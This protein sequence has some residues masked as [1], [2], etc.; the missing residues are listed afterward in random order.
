MAKDKLLKSAFVMAAM[1]M[2]SRILGLMRD[3]VSAKIFGLGWV[4]DAFLYAFMVPNFFRRIVGEGAL[5]SAF[6]PVY[7]DI[8]AKQGEEAA[9]KYSNLVYTFMGAALF[10][11]ILAVEVVLALLLKFGVF[12]DVIRLAI[13]LL[14]VMFP[15]LWFLCAY[16]IG[17]GILN[18]HGRFFV[19]MI[20]PVLMNM[21]WIATMLWIFPW[22]SENQTARLHILAWALTF[23]G[24][25]HWAVEWPFLKTIGFQFQFKWRQL[26]FWNSP[27][28]EGLRRSWKL[29]TPVL[30]SFGAVQ[31]NMLIDTAFAYWVGPGANSSLW[32]GNRVMQLPLSMFGVAMGSALLPMLS[33]QI[34]NNQ[35]E[36]ARQTL[37]FSLTVTFMIVLP[38]SAGLIVLAPDIMRLLFER[39]EFDAAATARTASVLAAYAWGLFAYSGQKMMITGYYAAHDSKTPMRISLFSLLLNVVLNF[40]L[41]PF[42][43]ETGLALSTSISAIVQLLL[44]MFFYPRCVASFPFRETVKSFLKTLIASVIMAL[45]ARFLLNAWSGAAPASS[46]TMYAIQVLGTIAAAGV[47][48][49][50]IS[51]VIQKKEASQVFAYLRRRK[52]AKAGAEGNR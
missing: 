25:L 40:L 16:A 38:A 13:S 24:F 35:K 34:A 20:G 28:H 3:I 45:A 26:W 21:I 22:A 8:R 33:N 39:G 46:A 9:F 6:I 5:A 32:Y 41:M 44:L 10:V 19:P 50:L 43:R 14:Q 4:W 18:S 17:M 36:E 15:H 30:L 27:E 29:L 47:F 37:A 49:V 42:L 1:I 31:V 51:I 11:F 23:A 52:P 48:Y 7:S 2:L 12:P